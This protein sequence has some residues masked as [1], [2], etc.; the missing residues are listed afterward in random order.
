MPESQT[1]PNQSSSLLPIPEVSVQ[2]KY[3]SDGDLELGGLAQDV[4]DIE[5]ELT[6][7]QKNGKTPLPNLKNAQS[8]AY[9]DFYSAA[10]RL[11]RNLKPHLSKE[12]Q[13][14]FRKSWKTLRNR[15]DPELYSKESVGEL[16]EFLKQALK[17]ANLSELGVKSRED[18]LENEIDI[19]QL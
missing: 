18:E 12:D 16:S 5:H 7:E 3:F 6:L 11:M 13:T 19:S 9:K 14:Q 15:M 4:D 8:V 1:P 10:M 17:N 2:K